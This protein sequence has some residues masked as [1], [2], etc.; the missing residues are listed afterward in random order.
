[1]D[2]QHIVRYEKKD[3]N[4]KVV[5]GVGLTTVIILIAILVMLSD[6]F[7]V[8]ETDRVYETQLKPE[9]V[10]LNEILAAEQEI[11]TTYKLID[12]EKGVYRIPIE[13]AMQ[14]LADETA[15]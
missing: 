9:S 3:I 15:N 13:Q 6:Y 1:M 11:L 8:M 14:L 10:S 4:I 2:K 7:T 12:A 5:M